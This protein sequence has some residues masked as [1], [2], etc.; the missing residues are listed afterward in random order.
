MTKYDVELLKKN[1]EFMQT[2]SAAVFRKSMELPPCEMYPLDMSPFP[3]SLTLS[4][5]DPDTL[6]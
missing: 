2:Q 5:F 1:Y 4:D 6:N 3:L